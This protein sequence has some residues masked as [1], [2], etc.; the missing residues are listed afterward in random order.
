MPLSDIAF[1]D[2]PDGTPH[3]ATV[4]KFPERTTRR[5]ELSGEAFGEDQPGIEVTIDR[6]PFHHYADDQRDT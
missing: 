4:G 2:L 3:P 6:T 5:M 1:S